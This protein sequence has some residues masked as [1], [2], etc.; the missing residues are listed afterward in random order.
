MESRSRW[1]FENRKTIIGGLGFIFS[2]ATLFLFLSTTSS[3]TITR[4]ERLAA[5]DDFFEY[6][7]GLTCQDETTKDIVKLIVQLQE[8][9]LLG[10]KISIADPRLSKAETL[11]LEVGKNEVNKQLKNYT[12]VL[13]NEKVKKIESEVNKEM[14]VTVHYNEEVLKADLV[15][16]H[17]FM[18]TLNKDVAI[19]D[20][21]N[22]QL[23]TYNKGKTTMVLVNGPY[24][25][26]FEIIVK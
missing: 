25:K 19:Y 1:L 4:N 9:A 8:N 10:L 7:E 21:M 6:C 15:S 5:L 13:G 18:Y 14:P 23:K 2:L 20:N 11:L 24:R 17:T 12:L 16:Y 26:E 22:N 3:A